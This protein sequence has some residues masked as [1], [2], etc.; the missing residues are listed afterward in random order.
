MN[1]SSIQ[2]RLANGDENLSY[3]DKNTS[4]F[5]NSFHTSSIHMEGG[6]PNYHVTNLK[7]FK[8]ENSKNWLDSIQQN[9][10]ILTTKLELI[11]ISSFV[12]SHRKEISDVFSQV[13]RDLI[14]SHLEY[15]PK[16]IRTIEPS[17]MSATSREE[18]TKL[19]VP[20]LVAISLSG[21]GFVL[22]CCFV[23]FKALKS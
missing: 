1:Y 9:P 14:G 11:P 7:A 19:S 2:L 12:S 15:I 4:N 6:N 3:E 5:E 21:L 8:S 10:S 16:R 17:I 20:D 13:Y 22:L 23:L 18:A